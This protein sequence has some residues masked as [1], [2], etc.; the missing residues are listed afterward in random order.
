MNL[1]DF[2]IGGLIANAM[3]HLI[4]GLTKAHFLGLFGYTPK[5]NILYAALSLILALALFFYQYGIDKLFEN[6]FL[7]GALAVLVSYFIL[8]KFLVTFY[9]KKEK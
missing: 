8:G 5:G 3:P 6:G 9:A 4:F 1:I 2:I 7:L